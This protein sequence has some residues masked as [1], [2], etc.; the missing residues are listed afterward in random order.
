MKKSVIL[1]LSALALLSACSSETVDMPKGEQTEIAFSTFIDKS[2][3][4][5]PSYTTTNLAEFAVYGYI[6]ENS[7]SASKE[8]TDYANLFKGTTV[9]KDADK[10]TWGYD[11]TKYW[12]DGAT[13]NFCALAPTSLDNVNVV[14]GD[15]KTY[16]LTITN[17]KN[18][19]GKTDI[20]FAD[21]DQ[22]KYSKGTTNT[23]VAFTFQ[24]LLSK[25]KFSF[26]SGFPSS[27]GIAIG[28]KDVKIT[29]AVAQGTVVA[30][31]KTTNWKDQ[32]G[33]V[34]LNFGRYGAAGS[35]LPIDGTAGS[36]GDE[37]LLIP[38]AAQDYTVTFTVIARV[39][40][41]EIAD[42]YITAT[43]KNQELKA[44]YAYNFTAT[45]SHENIVD[46]GLNPITF[47]VTSVDNWAA[48]SGSTVTPSSS[49]QNA[50]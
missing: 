49:T 16:D 29:N 47:S 32:T 8:L 50:N 15:D 23:N 19:D 25:V 12:I 6:V 35:A 31:A 18:T 17:F 42:Y 9:K 11:G 44:G 4:A 21:P 3:K 5:D 33:T 37:L 39:D 26:S 41:K 10:G 43:I 30:E 7:S 46:N 2:T 28:I 20:I 22:V 36:I 34:T 45:I 14:V 24:H 40:D 1:S 13:Y 38:T 27:S 48:G